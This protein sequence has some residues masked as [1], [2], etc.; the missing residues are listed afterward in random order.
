MA[1]IEKSATR[2]PHDE[3]S[4]LLSVNDVATMLRC[5]VRHVRRL[6]DG[7]V[8]P[9]PIKLGS[10]IRWRRCDIESWIAGGC[11]SCRTLPTGK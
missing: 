2:P 1:A 3:Q 11:K 10:L 5:S 9:K 7:G 8:L 4:T 6:A